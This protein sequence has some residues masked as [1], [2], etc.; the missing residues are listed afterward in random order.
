MSFFGVAWENII[1]GL[2]SAGIVWVGSLASKKVKEKYLERRFPIA[3]E[4]ITE[5]DD[6]VQGEIVRFTAPARLKQKGRKIVGITALESNE[7]EWA[8][9][10]EIS[11]GG[12]VFG[13]Y[14]ASDPHDKSIGNF[15]LYI[16]HDNTLE[17][18]WSGYDSVNKKI[19][20]GRYFFTPVFRGFKL[21]DLQEDF[22]PTVIAIS[23]FQ[24]GKDYLSADSL[25]KCLQK[26]GK[27]FARVALNNKREI[28]GFCLSS[29]L[30]TDEIKK[31]LKIKPDQF[32]NAL[33]YTSNIGFIN[34]LIVK[35]DYQR[36]GIGTA[37]VKDSIN[38]LETNGA[39][40]ICSV[41]WRSKKGVNIGGILKNHKFKEVLEVPDYWKEDS[42]AKKYKCVDCGAPPCHCSAVIFLKLK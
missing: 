21:E 24:L 15:F 8:L 16:N 22:I 28:I 41:G 12:H 40:V 9:E 5:Y 17:G 11:K 13:I 31:L 34:V 39:T 18:L 2:L 42:L 38:L 19:N 30:S 27:Y 10:G 25:K 6:E 26:E 32:P 3:G 37:L 33:N 14:Y 1:V 36:K 29:I 20:S 7:R 4:Y 35:E 23:D